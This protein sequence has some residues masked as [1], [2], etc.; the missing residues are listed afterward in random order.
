MVRAI[1]GRRTRGERKDDESPDI[2]PKWCYEFD[3][4]NTI[5]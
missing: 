5:P 2:F 3:T 4:C 1:H